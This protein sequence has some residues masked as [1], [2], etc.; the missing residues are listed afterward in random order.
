MRTIQIA[1]CLLLGTVFVAGC[2][3][4][5]N[6]TELTDTP[7]FA[8]SGVA[9][10]VSVGGADI[11]EALGQPTGCDANFSLTARQKADDS[12]GGEWQDTFAGGGEG[13]HVTIDCLN[14]VGNGAV[15]GGVITHGTEGGVDVS[16]LRALTAVVDNGTSAN[17]PADRISFSF[18][19]LNISCTLFPPAVFPLFNLANGQVTVR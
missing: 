19:G 2:T 11:C 10:R 3:E 18:T 17:D 13:I 4:S 14:V 8:G 1:S 7:L 9:H 12:V 5:N 15:V 16:G 6:P